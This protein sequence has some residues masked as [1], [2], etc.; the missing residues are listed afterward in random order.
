NFAV[1]I[2]LCNFARKPSNIYFLKKPSTRLRHCG[3]FPSAPLSGKKVLGRCRQI[4]ENH[5]SYH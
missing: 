5:A 3:F 1:W 4:P 2:T